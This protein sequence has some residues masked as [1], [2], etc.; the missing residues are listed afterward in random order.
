MQSFLWLMTED[1]FN[2]IKRRIWEFLFWRDQRGRV[3]PPKIAFIIFNCVGV[4]VCLHVHMCTCYRLETVALLELKLL[5]VGYCQS[6]LLGPDLASLEEQEVLI[7]AEPSFQSSSNL[8]FYHS[9]ATFLPWHA[10]CGGPNGNG[11]C[12]LIYLNLWFPVG[13]LFRKDQEVWPCW[14]YDVTGGV[15]LLE[16]WCHC[17]C[18]LFGGMMSLGVWPCWRYVT[19]AGLWGFKTPSHLLCSPTWW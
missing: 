16:V 1:F 12:R 17:G 10:S 15:A 18:G 5:M 14:R 4:R 19:G 6:W 8:V 11:L 7:T 2:E 3:P 13:R 9:V